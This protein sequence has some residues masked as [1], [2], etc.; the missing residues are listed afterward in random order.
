MKEKDE[1]PSFP[2]PS[3]PIMAKKPRYDPETGK[4]RLSI[5]ERFRAFNYMEPLN[6]QDFEQLKRELRERGI[7]E[8]S[9]CGQTYFDD[10]ERTYETK[11]VDEISG[12]D[13]EWVVE[14]VD[15]EFRYLETV[16]T[17]R[18]LR[19]E[20]GALTPKERG[21]KERVTLLDL[22]KRLQ[23][24][25]GVIGPA[26]GGANTMDVREDVVKAILQ[27]I[28]E[29]SPD[30]EGG[31]LRLRERD[32]A[33]LGDEAIWGEYQEC[34]EELLG[35]YEPMSSPGRIVLHVD[36][37]AALFWHIIREVVRAG[38]TFRQDDLRRLA[39]LA[40]NKTYYHEHFHLFCDI[41]AHLIPGFA[42]RKDHDK[43][44]ALA[45]AFS[46]LRIEREHADGRT[47]ISGI[48]PTHHSQFLLLAFDYRA[49]GYRDWKNFSSLELF[50]EGLAACI[51]DPREAGFLAASGVPVGEFLYV[52]L[53]KVGLRQGRG[54][55][56]IC[57]EDW[58]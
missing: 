14:K 15:F 7:G 25:N 21:E 30:Q 9:F 5:L 37:L 50:K 43:E 26:K 48:A 47:W 46:R 31:A 11:G 58:Q 53:E 45:V 33:D 42:A 57:W 2:C 49:R 23:K 36:K 38:F 41:Q 6:V 35:H 27:P 32:I 39:W 52:Q 51:V 22:P 19:R 3:S 44:E 16:R 17:G 29:M 13:F 55:A 20:H 34:G 40:V 24:M 18:K 12:A 28:A 56:L 8:V 1:S 54:H 10:V 4:Y